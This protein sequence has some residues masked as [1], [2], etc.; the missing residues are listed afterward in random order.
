MKD[1]FSTLILL[2]KNMLE[3]KDAERE[4]LI[5]RRDE[6]SSLIS[7][8]GARVQSEEGYKASLEDDLCAY[9]HLPHYIVVTI[10]YSVVSIAMELVVLAIYLGC[11]YYLIFNCV[12]NGL[13]KF[14]ACGGMGVLT[15]Y[16]FLKVTKFFYDICKDEIERVLGSRK[17][18]KKYNSKEEIQ[19]LIRLVK[20][21][22]QD[23]VNDLNAQKGAKQE[24]ETL[25][26]TLSQE[27]EGLEERLGLT[28]NTFIE[29]TL[30]IQDEGVEEKLNAE[31]E[32]S[33]IEK[34]VQPLETEEGKKFVATRKEEQTV[35]PQS[36]Q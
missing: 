23:I 6:I 24:L 19:E 7:E 31:Y 29:A 33:G 35:V 20:E 28:S 17:I 30:R 32:A 2:L 15:T 22:I 12:F 25:I 4:E 26:G 14:A 3:K 18:R 10:V 27:I 5:K 16:L 11:N 9:R 8:L 34:K 13:A 21:K 1:K 36:R